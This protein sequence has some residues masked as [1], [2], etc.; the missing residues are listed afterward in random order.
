M[1]I[2]AT[3]IDIEE[4]NRIYQELNPIQRLRK[5]FSDFDH[6][7]I[8]VT[9]SFGTTSGILM[10]MVSK[11]A[12]GHPI[13]FIDTTFC[14]NK[15]I[16]Y[17]QTL[18]DLL[19]LNIVNV[20]PDIEDNTLARETKMWERDTDQCCHLNKTKPFEPFKAKKKIW[21]SGL[22]MNQTPFRKNLDIFERRGDIIKMHPN[23]DTSAAQFDMF[24]ADNDIP[25]H[26]LKAEGF[27][28]VGCTHCTLKGT[29]RSGRWA[30]SDK[31]ECGI[32]L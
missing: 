16:T 27:D 19:G 6:E 21:V 30:N 5:V 23:I 10:G 17:K 25:P 13:H 14:F 4:L 15:T 12:P 8:L 20:L 9:S 1:S 22:L 32:H 11:A 18:T 7:D 26:P 3:D 2:A 24:L 28:S 31:T 29:G